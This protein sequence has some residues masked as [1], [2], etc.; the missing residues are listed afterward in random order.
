MRGDRRD[1]A[2]EAR[3]YGRSPS[4]PGSGRNGAHVQAL[5]LPVTLAARDRAGAAL[6]HHAAAPVGLQVEAARLVRVA[7]D[8]VRDA[9]AEANSMWFQ[10]PGREARRGAAGRTK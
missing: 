1:G 8:A 2:G 3:F 10:M 7:V 9:S 5:A 4:R 6:L